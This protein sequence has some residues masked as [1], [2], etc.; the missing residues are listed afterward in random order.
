MEI[1]DPGEGGRDD[2]FSAHFCLQI[3]VS[4]DIE[5]AIL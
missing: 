4:C 5:E 1:E 2:L 3:M